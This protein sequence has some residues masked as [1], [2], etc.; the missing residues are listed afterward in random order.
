M[1]F[2]EFLKII[3]ESFLV[4]DIMVRDMRYFIKGFIFIS[5]KGYKF[6]YFQE[7]NYISIQLKFLGE[8]KRKQKVGIYFSILVVYC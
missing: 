7:I 8:K 4:L 6:V 2:L 3:L 1:N 5:Q